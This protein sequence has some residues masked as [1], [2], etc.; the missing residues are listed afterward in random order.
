VKEVLAFKVR[1]MLLFLIG[2][3]AMMPYVMLE[4]LNTFL[5]KRVDI[6]FG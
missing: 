1:L 5:M 4:I 2:W 6:C 3:E